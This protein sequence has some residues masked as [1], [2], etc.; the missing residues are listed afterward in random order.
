MSYFLHDLLVIFSL[1]PSA[2]MEVK[3]PPGIIKNLKKRIFVLSSVGKRLQLNYLLDFH[4]ETKR[5][6]FMYLGFDFPLSTPFS[7]IAK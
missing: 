7:L 2:K 1:I 4:R 3:F 6:F 5:L